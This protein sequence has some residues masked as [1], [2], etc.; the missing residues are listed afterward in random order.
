MG[1][2]GYDETAKEPSAEATAPGLLPRSFCRVH[3]LWSFFILS[4]PELEV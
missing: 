1:S 4:Q 3:G 2:M